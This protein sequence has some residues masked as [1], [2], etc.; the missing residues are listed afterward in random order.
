MIAL[1][2][3]TM[4]SELFRSQVF[5]Q[6]NGMPRRELPHNANLQADLL[7]IMTSTIGVSPGAGEGLL[8]TGLPASS[9]PVLA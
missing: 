7:Y 9:F 3:Y 4:Y 5:V 1:H 6:V 8:N 2:R